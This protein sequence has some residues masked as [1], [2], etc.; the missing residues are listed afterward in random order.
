MMG[1][2]EGAELHGGILLFTSQLTNT[3]KLLIQYNSLVIVML[4]SYEHVLDS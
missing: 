4:D 2:K 1:D 3:H